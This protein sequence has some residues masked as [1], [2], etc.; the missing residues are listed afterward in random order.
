MHNEW[1]EIERRRER[2]REGSRRIF[3]LGALGGIAFLAWAQFARIDESTVTPEVSTEAPLAQPQSLSEP[4]MVPVPR[5]RSPSV[6]QPGRQTY[7]RVY[8]CMVNGQ[9]TVS[10]IRIS[11]WFAAGFPRRR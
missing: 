2:A 9:R 10:P 6:T 3:M 8:E 1:D 4:Q 7:M 5:Y 11:G